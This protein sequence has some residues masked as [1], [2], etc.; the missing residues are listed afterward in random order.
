MTDTIEGHADEIPGQELEVHAAAP[1][2]LFGTDD[3]A[4]MIAQATK[5]ADA[6]M[7][8]VRKKELAVKIGSKE[9]LLV[10]AWTCL[11]SL[12]GVYPRTVWSRQLDDGWEARV[13]AVTRDGA[14]VGAA[15]ASCLRPERNWKNRDEYALRSMAQTRAMGKALR[16]PLG[17]VAVLAGFEATPAEEM[18]QTSSAGA[19]TSKKGA[20]P[21]GDPGE[22]KF[23][24]SAPDKYKGR[25][26]RDVYATEP[27]YIE[28]VSRSAKDEGI[29]DAALRFV[30]AAQV[31]ADDPELPF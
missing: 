29:R 12:V 3:P 28:A 13:E 22:V 2:T 26:I 10:E 17:F 20:D 7:S 4:A 18:P 16:M 14:V 19:R 21:A 5:V 24:N 31:Q 25:T 15:E 8:V 9:Y 1:V 11:G 27:G 6:L 30:E 23:P